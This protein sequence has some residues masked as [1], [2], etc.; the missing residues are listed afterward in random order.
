LLYCFVY[1]HVFL[2]VFSVLPPSDNSVAVSSNIFIF[3]VSIQPLGLFWQEPEPSQ[4]TGMTL[5]RCVS[6]QVLR[7]SLPLL[8]P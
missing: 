7:G 1:V 6:R 4:A 3:V 8:S 5:A 2:L